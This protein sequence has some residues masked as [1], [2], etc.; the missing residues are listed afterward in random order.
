MEALLLAVLFVFMGACGGDKTPKPSAPVAVAPAG[1]GLI[2]AV[3]ESRYY[4]ESD[5]PDT[6]FYVGQEVSWVL[7]RAIGYTNPS[8]MITGL[9]HSGLSFNGLTRTL[10]GQPD[11]LNPSS[12][13]IYYIAAGSLVEDF[14]ITYVDSTS[15]E[16]EEEEEEE[17]PEEVDPPAVEAEDPPAGNGTENAPRG[18]NGSRNVDS[19]NPPKGNGNNNQNSGNN[20]SNTV[21]NHS[22]FDEDFNDDSYTKGDKHNLGDITPDPT[23]LSIRDEV[24][25]DDEGDTD[26]RDLFFFSLSAER[27]ISLRVSDL[28]ENANLHLWNVDDLDSSNE[29]LPKND[30]YGP[31]IERSANGGT[32]AETI[33]VV[34]GSGNYVIWVVA[35]GGGEG[36]FTHYRLEVVSYDG[37]PPP[38]EWGVSDLHITYEG[39]ADHQYAFDLPKFRGR[40]PIRYTFELQSTWPVEDD[41]TFDKSDHKLRFNIPYNPGGLN[42][43]LFLLTATDR[44]GSVGIRNIRIVV[45]KYQPPATWSVRGEQDCQEGETSDDC[46]FAV[47]EVPE[48]DHGDSWFVEFRSRVTSNG[49]IDRRGVRLD[50]QNQSTNATENHF[51]V[52]DEK[53]IIRGFW[54][55]VFYEV[56]ARSDD[57]ADL[58]SV[59][60]FRTAPCPRGTQSK[61]GKRYRPIK[62]NAGTDIE[63]IDHPENEYQ[64]EEPAPT[65]RETTS[66][67]VTRTVVRYPEDGGIATAAPAGMLTVP[68][69]DAWVA[70]KNVYYASVGVHCPYAQAIIQNE[71]RRRE[72]DPNEESCR[73]PGAFV[74]KCGDV[75]GEQDETL[76]PCSNPDER[77]ITDYKVVKTVKYD[78]VDYSDIFIFHYAREGAVDCPSGY[79]SRIEKMAGGRDGCSWG[80]PDVRQ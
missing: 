79:G 26:K 8:Y 15:A 24:Q 28:T 5:I 70:D 71:V 50:P 45:T 10:S 32:S 40:N 21:R 51:Q 33:D 27:N 25:D 52:K 2:S 18:G 73:A 62:T 3:D 67:G 55:G 53:F 36:I 56:R 31:R 63:V 44:L 38:G 42:E 58:R 29:Y 64:C 22:D 47:L 49:S 75:L 14:T 68:E 1:K 76:S 34:L 57:N 9:S 30:D 80:A 4:F 12:F 7:P 74:S 41:V 61:D 48:P 60:S 35:E 37:T 13:Y 72:S 59:G 19:R 11:D 43:H 66:G 17:T 65:L 20:N 39:Y 16:V 46:R 23:I 69:T 6:T 54:A 77:Q 78:G